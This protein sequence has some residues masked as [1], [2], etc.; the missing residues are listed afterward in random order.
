MSHTTYSIVRDQEY[1]ELSKVTLSGNVLDIGGSR[2]SGYHELVQG[3]P[4]FT[5]VNYG[6][7]HPGQDL[8]FNAEEKFPL[9]DASYDHVLTMNVLEHIW[10]THNVFSEV[11]RVLKSGGLFVSA[12]PYMHHIHGSPDDYNRYT[13]SAFKKYAERYGF[14]MVEI[15]TLGGGLLSLIYQ[16]VGGW[17]YF[18]ILKTFA[19]WLCT[20]LDDIFSVIPQYE[21]LAR[22]IP[23]GY[24]WI[25]KKK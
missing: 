17:L 18:N 5:V 4:V 7:M 6:D 23:L 16:C 14:E 24:F 21:K 9:G 3:S 10:D 11:A 25:M 22:N 2:K 1:K 12:V 20:T 15:K 8:N 19:K 13:E